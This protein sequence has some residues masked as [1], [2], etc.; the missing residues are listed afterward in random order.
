MKFEESSGGIVY[1]R[2]LRPNGL[3]KEKGEIYILVV[4]HSAHHGWVFS[5]RTN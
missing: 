2:S 3:K 5:E 4:Q 1:K